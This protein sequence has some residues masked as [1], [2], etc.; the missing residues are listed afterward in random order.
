MKTKILL[1]LIISLGFILRV[2]Y[3]DQ[4]PKTLYGDEQAFAWNAYNILKLGQDEY[5]NP[6]PLQFRSFDDYKSPLPIYLLVPFIKIFDLSIF[7]I[8]LPIVLFSTMTVLLT[9]KLARIFFNNKVSLMSSFLLAV[10]PWHVHLSRGFFEST[11]SL[12]FFIGGIYF[13]LINKN[14]LGIVILSMI[15]FALSL[16][17]YFTPRILVPIFLALLVWY[18]KAVK[19]RSFWIGLIILFF[20]SLPLLKFAIFDSGLSRFNKLNEAMNRTISESVNKERFAS[21]LSPSWKIIFH[22]KATVWIRLVT[23]NY[24]EQL[25]FNYWYVFGDSSLRYFLGNMGMFYLLELPFMLYGL[26]ILV[27]DKNRVAIFF[28]FWILLSP[29]PASFVGKPFALRSMSMIPVPFFIVA[30]GV[31][32]LIRK[33]NNVRFIMLGVILLTLAYVCSIFIVLIRYYREYPV[34]AATWWGWENKAALDYVKLNESRYEQIFL[35]DYYSGITLAYAVYNKVDPLEY[36]RVIN[37]PVVLADSRHFFR[38]GKLYFGSLDLDEDRLKSKIMP[39]KS[40]YIGRPEEPEG[41]DRIVAP[42]DGR[43]LYVIHDTLKKDCY[44]FNLDSC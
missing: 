41:E 27:R 9:F 21:Q 19:N 32:G 16:Y 6:Y 33:V 14:R 12:F 26:Y 18:M 43:L 39:S 40:L 20:I 31:N 11:L 3:I 23:Q 29:I 38:F 35:S 7:T 22:N 4:F 2:A 17:S 42:D 24:L 8:R 10:S 34:Y 25:S 36:R 30:Y 44:R 28:I 1:L 15:F 13:F 5:G 37:D